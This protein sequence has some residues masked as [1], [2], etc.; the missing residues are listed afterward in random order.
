MTA[1]SFLE[2]LLKKDLVAASTMLANGFEIN[3][4]C[5]NADDGW[6]GLHYAAEH[7]LVDVAVWLLDHGADPNVRT[8]HGQTPLYISID[9]ELGTAHQRFVV[10]GA[11]YFVRDDEVALDA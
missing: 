2:A 7:G 3:S 11:K 9:S 5:G 1:T 4:A 10:T 6:T 8:I